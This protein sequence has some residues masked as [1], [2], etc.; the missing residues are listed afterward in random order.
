[1]KRLLVLAVAFALASAGSAYAGPCKVNGN[2]GW[3]NGGFD[4][5]SPGSYHGKGVS[6][7]GPGASNSQ[8]S[9]KYVNVSR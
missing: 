6:R 9:T 1:M 3:G 4:G 2:N 5:T 8:S 7:G